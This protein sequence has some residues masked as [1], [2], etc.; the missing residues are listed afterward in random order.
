MAASPQMET[1][2]VVIL[3]KLN[4]AI[5]HP[6]WFSAQHLLRP[7]E[8]QD[9]EVQLVHPDAA[10]M[11][12]EWL[13]LQ[14]VRER[15]QASTTQSQ[16]FEPLRDLVSGIFSLL[17][18]TPVTAL[19]IN[20]DFHFSLESE[21]QWHALGHKL[22]PQENWPGLKRPGLFHLTVQGEREDNIKGYIRVIVEPSPGFSHGVYVSV[23]HHFE[24]AGESDQTSGAARMVELLSSYWEQSMTASSAIAQDLLRLADEG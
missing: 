23:N 10:V 15:F 12:M 5:F 2:H 8:T 21:R 14:V 9:A 17:A 22:A 19:G 3:G 11:R 7:Q 24:L 16:Y 6:A 20:R 13:Q 1:A 18:Y 4:P